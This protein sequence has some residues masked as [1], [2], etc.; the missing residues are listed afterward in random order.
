VP[1]FQGALQCP[2]LG[3]LCTNLIVPNESD[4]TQGIAEAE[5]EPE[6]EY[7]PGPKPKPKRPRKHKGWFINIS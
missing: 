3:I 5:P 2:P 4:V 6:P 1:R 7:E